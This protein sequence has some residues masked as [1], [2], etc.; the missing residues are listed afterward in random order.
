MQYIYETILVTESRLMFQNNDKSIFSELY[1][2]K[3]HFKTV[4]NHYIEND[5]SM[6]EASGILQRLR[7]LYEKIH[8]KNNM[9]VI[10][11]PLNPGHRSLK[12]IK[13]FAKSL[14]RAVFDETKYKHA[15]DKT[16]FASFSDLQVI[17]VLHGYLLMLC[18]LLFLTELKG[19]ALERLILQF[20]QHLDVI[21]SRVICGNVSPSLPRFCSRWWG[22]FRKMCTLKTEICT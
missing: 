20:R 11:S 6:L 22:F 2:Y 9:K 1:V 17:W 7:W 5:L 18:V 14:Q 21:G 16:E 8:L 10:T 3:T 4:F 12:R 13:S 19:Y 15:N